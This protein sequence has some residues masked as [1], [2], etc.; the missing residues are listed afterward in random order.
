MEFRFRAKSGNKTFD[1]PSHVWLQGFLS[2]PTKL[3]PKPVKIGQVMNKNMEKQNTPKNPGR[4]VESA[5]CGGH[6]EVQ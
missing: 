3:N 2:Q 1:E 6:L 4:R 5:T